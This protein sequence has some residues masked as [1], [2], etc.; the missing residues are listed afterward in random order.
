MLILGGDGVK[1]C[2][3]HYGGFSSENETSTRSH[4]F[5]ISLVDHEA[6]GS[7]GRVC[8]SLFFLF[9]PC[10]CVLTTR[11]GRGHGACRPTAN[12]GM[13]VVRNAVFARCRHGVPDSCISFTHGRV[14][15]WLTLGPS[16]GIWDLGAMTSGMGWMDVRLKSSYAI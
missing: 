3:Q 7:A 11:F 15:P 8:I 2:G 12:H 10:C 9:W 6:K 16:C 1:G 5:R 14:R 4:F 13:V